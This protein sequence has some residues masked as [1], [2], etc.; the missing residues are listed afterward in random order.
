M[1][2]CGQSNGQYEEVQ[3]IKSVYELAMVLY[4]KHWL[5]LWRWFFFNWLELPTEKFILVVVD[6][7][8][9]SEWKISRWMHSEVVFIQFGFSSPPPTPNP[10]EQLEELAAL[11]SKILYAMDKS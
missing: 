6:Y 1:E 5:G 8:W 11:S 7:L 10:V 4:F 2:K 9:T 3:L